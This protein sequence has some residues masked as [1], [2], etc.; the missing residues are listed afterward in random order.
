MFISLFYGD[1]YFAS[2]G[3][4]EGVSDELLHWKEKA[5]QGFLLH[6][7]PKEK[8]CWLG[9]C[10]GGFC[11]HCIPSEVL[12]MCCS[13]STLSL[14]LTQKLFSVWLHGQGMLLFVVIYS[15]SR[16]HAQSNTSKISTSKAIF[17][18]SIHTLL[19]VWLNV[20]SYCRWWLK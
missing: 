20:V 11:L 17:C 15:A 7:V 16:Y 8:V 12:P 5:K 3:K 2:G 14:G 10:T 19:L 1:L 6:F 4:S 13:Y 18:F 9:L